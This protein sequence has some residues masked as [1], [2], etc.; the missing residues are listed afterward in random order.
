VS[1]LPIAY[2]PLLQ[3]TQTQP[4]AEARGPQSSS[5]KDQAP[6]KPSSYLP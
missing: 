1:I 4:A 6:L 2:D 3:K 5:I